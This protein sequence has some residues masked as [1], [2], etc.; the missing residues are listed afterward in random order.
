M[1]NSGH[2]PSWTYVNDFSLWQPGIPFVYQ[3][4]CPIRGPEAP[5]L[6]TK[7]R[8]EKNFLVFGIDLGLIISVLCAR[9]AKY[10][11][12]AHG[13]GDLGLIIIILTC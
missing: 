4:I 3:N 6:M 12:S 1:N 5:L 11:V 2:R 13:Q 9:W 8:S 7:T 10:S